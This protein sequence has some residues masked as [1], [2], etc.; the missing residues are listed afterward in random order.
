MA[1]NQQPLDIDGRQAANLLQFAV[2]SWAVSVEVFLRREFGWNYIGAKGGA[3]TVAGSG[4]PRVL[5]RPR[6]AP[7]SLVFRGLPG[8][9]RR[10]PGRKP[11]GVELAATRIIPTTPDG[12]G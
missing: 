5:A 8:D 1:G 11:G 2:E 9:V 4:L 3:G 6:P 7:A 12:L 10:S